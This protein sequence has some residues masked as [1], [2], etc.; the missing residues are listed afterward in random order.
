MLP[1]R[2]R[3]QMRRP[4][5]PPPFGPRIQTLGI[6]VLFAVAGQCTIRRFICPDPIGSPP[7]ASVGKAGRPR[8]IPDEAPPG[9]HE[10][11]RVHLQLDPVD[12]SITAT[13]PARLAL[14]LCTGS[15][16]KSITS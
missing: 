2:G 13:K 8:S 10:R 15:Q 9:V 7:L 12:T 6:S 4:T 14:P 3:P 11:R 5:T 16:A 1:T